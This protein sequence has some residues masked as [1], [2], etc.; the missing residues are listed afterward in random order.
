MM[1]NILVIDDDRTVLDIVNRIIKKI[2]HSVAYLCATAVEA[3][4]FARKLVPDLTISDFDL[5]ESRNGVDLALSIRRSTKQAI[6][7]I[8]MS[9]SPQNDEMAKTNG[10]EFI[11]KPFYSNELIALVERSCHPSVSALRII[12]S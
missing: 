6:P 10:F 1:K 8:I 4:E 3:R 9:G 7:V 2:G 5:S 11:G 12:L